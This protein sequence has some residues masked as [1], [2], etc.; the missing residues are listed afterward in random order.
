MDAECGIRE[1]DEMSELELTDRDVRE[2]LADLVLHLR[3]ES[4]PDYTPDMVA[5]RIQERWKEVLP[6]RTRACPVPT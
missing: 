5:W 3:G 1:A 2:S 6:R 4:A